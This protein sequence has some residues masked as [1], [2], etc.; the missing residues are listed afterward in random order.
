MAKKKEYL[1][2]FTRRGKKDILEN[3]AKKEYLMSEAL[4][5]K[6]TCLPNKRRCTNQS[7]RH[8]SLA[9]RRGMLVQ[10]LPSIGF[11][12]TFFF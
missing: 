7:L 6:V 12:F 3:V 10:A 11:D 1:N 5:C 8:W 4:N 2:N 9:R